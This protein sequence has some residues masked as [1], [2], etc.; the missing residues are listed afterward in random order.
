MDTGS[1]CC[2]RGMANAINHCLSRLSTTALDAVRC[3]T[4]DIKQALEAG[5]DMY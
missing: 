5:S 3:Y 1:V 2:K 4:T